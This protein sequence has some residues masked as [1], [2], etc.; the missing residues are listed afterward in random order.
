MARRHIYCKEQ[1]E[2]DVQVLL[3]LEIQ[4]LTSDSEADFS[5]IVN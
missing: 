4:N 2:K 5:F 3:Q 1:V